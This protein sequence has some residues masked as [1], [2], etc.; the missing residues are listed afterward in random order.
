[1]NEAGSKRKRQLTLFDYL[2]HFSQDPSQ[3]VLNLTKA[4]LADTLEHRA[5][6]RI[7]PEQALARKLRLAKWQLP[8]ADSYLQHT[9]KE[10]VVQLPD[11]FVSG[12][13][14]DALLNAIHC[15]TAHLYTASSTQQNLPEA[16]IMEET[17]MLAMGIATELYASHLVSTQ[18]RKRASSKTANAERVETPQPAL[19]IQLPVSPLEE[20]TSEKSIS[21]SGS[22]RTVFRP[23]AT[24]SSSPERDFDESVDAKTILHSSTRP[25]SSL[26]GASEDYTVELSQGGPSL[27]LTDRHTARA[28]KRKRQTGF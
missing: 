13:P 17:A 24:N 5:A 10:S 20:G 15:A 22:P 4:R 18:R 16:G 27:P 7:G 6:D 8:S 9:A 23:S 25:Q 3:D 26:T 2:T 11:R 28:K 12:L 21:Y 19:S 1:M 14:D